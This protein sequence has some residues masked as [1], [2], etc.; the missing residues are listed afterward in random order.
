MGRPTQR[1]SALNVCYDGVSR[2]WAYRY[3]LPR[4]HIL[5]EETVGRQTDGAGEEAAE[6]HR[7]AL[8]RG[9]RSHRLSCPPYFSFLFKKTQGCTPRDFRAGHGGRQR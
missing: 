9:G 4:Q 1:L 8:R 6:K 3:I 5:T 7:P 2:L